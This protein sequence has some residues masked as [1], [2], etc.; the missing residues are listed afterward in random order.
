[1]VGP[2]SCGDPACQFLRRPAASSEAKGALPE[3][4]TNPNQPL[5]PANLAL[6]S[7]SDR[8]S[9][10]SDGAVI[11]AKGAIAI[12]YTTAA[13]AA[14]TAAIAD[15]S[16]RPRAA[17]ARCAL[18]AEILCGAR[19]QAPVCGLARCAALGMPCARH[20]APAHASHGPY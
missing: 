10:T 14:A 11:A 13:A 9:G 17:H 6:M 3:A 5:S 4:R 1:M 2:P 7:P 8:L 15:L 12:M 16:G 19:L 20:L 18:P